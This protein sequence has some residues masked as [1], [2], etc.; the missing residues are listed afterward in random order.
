MLMS[1][2][3]IR[4]VTNLADQADLPMSAAARAGDRMVDGEA[5]PDA[6]ADDA[7]AR[8][9]MGANGFGDAIGMAS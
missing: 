5:R 8:H 7:W 9:A 4:P 2:P 3:P 6:L 1:M